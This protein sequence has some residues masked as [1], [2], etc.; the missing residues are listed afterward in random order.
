MAAEIAEERQEIDPV[1]KQMVEDEFAPYPVT[2]Q[3][4]YEVTGVTSIHPFT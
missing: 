2:C 4:Q 1:F 3:T